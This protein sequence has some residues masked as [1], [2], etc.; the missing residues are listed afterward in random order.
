M[1]RSREAVPPDFEVCCSCECHS[2]GSFLAAEG[3]QWPAW[4]TSGPGLSHH[5]RPGCPA[6]RK[7]TKGTFD[8]QGP[9]LGCTEQ[10][11]RTFQPLP[12][13]R[14]PFLLPEQNRAIQQGLPEGCRPPAWQRHGRSLSERS[15]GECFSGDSHLPPL[16]GG[17][18]SPRELLGY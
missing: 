16:P 5:Q 17:T 3:G 6:T 13:P 8:V 11:A 7:G 1:A 18:H 2:P 9:P 10:Q 15:K 14:P 12:H 4:V